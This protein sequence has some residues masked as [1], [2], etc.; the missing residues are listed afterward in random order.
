MPYL[1]TT[2]AREVVHSSSPAHALAEREGRCSGS[3]LLVSCRRPDLSQLSEATPP[4]IGNRQL[5]NRRDNPP[6][7]IPRTGGCATPG[8]ARRQLPLPILHWRRPPYERITQAA[9]S[10][11]ESVALSSEKLRPPNDNENYG[12]SNRGHGPPS[13]HR[14]LAP[15]DALLSRNHSADIS[16]QRLCGR[17][18]LLGADVPGQ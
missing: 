17:G 10:M 5:Q 11:P 16:V 8:Q 12:R 13:R 6:P 3:K 14:A 2:T 15:I 7:A 1:F 4:E 9:C 18:L